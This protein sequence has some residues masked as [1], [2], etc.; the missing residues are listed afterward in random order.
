MICLEWQANELL[1]TPQALKIATTGA[2]D[3]VNV[4]RLMV[5]FTNLPSLARNSRHTWT[6]TQ[7]TIIC[8]KSKVEI[9]TIPDIKPLQRYQHHR[10]I[11]RRLLLNLLGSSL[12]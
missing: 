11:N 9:V 8:E 1:M 5:A 10:G 3:L 6:H 7:D 2:K 4:L 12:R